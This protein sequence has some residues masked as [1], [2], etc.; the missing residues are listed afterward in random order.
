MVRFMGSQK[1][2]HDWATELK[3][4]ELNGGFILSFLRNLHAIFRSTYINLHS[5]QC[6][7][8]PF[9]PHPLQ[10]L[11]FVNVL[12]IAILIVRWYLIVVLICI[13]LIMG[14]VEHLFM[15]LLAICM[16]CLEKCLCKLHIGWG[17]CW[18]FVCLFVFLLKG[19]AEWG[20]NP[21][22]WWLGLYFC[23][24]CCLD[25]VYCTG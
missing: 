24:A 3:W 6:K 8:L 11:L 12:M 20:G 4:T 18:V 19:K 17:L 14:N 22:C 5:Q 7:R 21:V 16:S 13:S 9:S 25:G 10:H 15:C 2:R 23:F 1:V